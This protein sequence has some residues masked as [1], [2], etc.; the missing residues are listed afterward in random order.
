MRSLL[1]HGEWVPASIAMRMGALPA[2]RLSKAAGLVAMRDS[3]RTS[4]VSVVQHAQVAVPIADV[5]ADGGA[6]LG[7]H[8]RYSFLDPETRDSSLLALLHKVY[9]TLCLSGLL[10]PSVGKVCETDIRRFSVVRRG[11]ARCCFEAKLRCKRP[12]TSASAGK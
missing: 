6:G 4:P 3:L 11:Y 7:G 12:S 8:G 2:K 1:I 5:R 10:I 9:S